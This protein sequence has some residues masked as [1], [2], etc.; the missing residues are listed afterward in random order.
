MFSFLKLSLVILLIFCTVQTNAQPQ[1]EDVFNRFGF[2]AGANFSNMDF[3]KGIPHP[4]FRWHR[5]GKQA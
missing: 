5:R 1:E 2:Q 4:P 3:I